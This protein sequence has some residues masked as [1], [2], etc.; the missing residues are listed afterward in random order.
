[1]TASKLDRLISFERATLTDDGFSMVETWAPHGSP[2]WALRQ[3]VKDAEKAQ[4]GTVMSTVMARFQ[5]RSTDFTRGIDPT[6]RLICDGET[7]EIIGRKEASQYG[8]AQLLE[9]TATR[10]TDGA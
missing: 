9:F 4:A 8:R 6:D 1:M 10:R 5:V 7:W 2:I 3:D